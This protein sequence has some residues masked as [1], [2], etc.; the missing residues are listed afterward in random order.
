MGSIDQN[1]STVFPLIAGATFQGLYTSTTNFSEILISVETDT[2][3]QLIVNF[4]T[5]NGQDIGLAKTYTVSVPAGT[6]FTYSLKP[7]LRY[8]QVIL[9]NTNLVS[10][11]TYL[12]LETILKTAVV[13]EEGG[14]TPANNVNII[15]PLNGDGDVL[16]AG[17]VVVSNDVNTIITSP[18]IDGNVAINL[19]AINSDYLTD[20]SLNVNI[21][22]TSLAITNDALSNM[23]FTD[24]ILLVSDTVSQSYLSNIASNSSIIATNTYTRGNTLIWDDPIGA[25]GATTFFNLSDKQIKLLTFYGMSSSDTTLTLMFS[26]DNLNYYKS[27]YTISVLANETFGFS[28]ATN[29]NYIGIFSSDAVPTKLTVFM[30]Y[31]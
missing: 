8:Y 6:A 9:T 30:D 12:R 29:P 23:S 13:Y 10:E 18:L 4:S 31:S 14:S 1:N 20:S 15:S 5:N 28:V 27:Q 2:T 16:V 26:P 24:N 7:S 17:N 25:N 19:Q 21:T 11:Q 22:N 3:F